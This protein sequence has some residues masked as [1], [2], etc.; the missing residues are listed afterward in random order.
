MQTR[1]KQNGFSLIETIIYVLI[2]SIFSIGLF[3]FSKTLTS[4]RLY[5]QAVLEVN[6]QG[7]S[8]MRIFTHA[9]RS[10][11]RI[12]YP[13]QGAADSALIYTDDINLIFVDGTSCSSPHMCGYLVALDSTEQY[14]SSGSLVIWPQDIDRK[15]LTN[16][17][18]LVSGLSFSNLS[19]NGAPSI[20]K[21]SFTLTSTFGNPTYSA[22]FSGTAA[23]RQ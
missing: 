9:I 15:Y 23:L 16:N 19:Q 11:K 10:T 17:K 8:A 13:A 21:I 18:V 5:N 14:N 22:N 12:L 2:F 4:A 3:S 20:V 1:N 6:D 7:S